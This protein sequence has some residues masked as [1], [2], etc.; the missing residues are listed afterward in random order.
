MLSQTAQHRP[1]NPDCPS[2]YFGGC[3]M[4]DEW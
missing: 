4:A 1:S 3:G 2:N